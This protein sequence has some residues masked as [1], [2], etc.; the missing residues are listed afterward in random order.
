MDN[1]IDALP[2]VI[3]GAHFADKWFLSK[4]VL[5][6]V[7]VL[8]IIGSVSTAV[9]NV[10]LYLDQGK[11]HGSILLFSANSAWTIMMAVKGLLRV[12]NERNKAV[13]V[14]GRKPFISPQ[15]CK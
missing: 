3:L 7:Y 13:K 6:P 12:K 9:F 8:T 4:G 10:L 2:F 1:L 15:I 11:A 14:I 5:L